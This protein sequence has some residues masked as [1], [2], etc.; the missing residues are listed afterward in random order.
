MRGLIKSTG[1]ELLY[2][3][4]VSRITNTNWQLRFAGF[5]RRD[6]SVSEGLIW[7]LFSFRKGRRMTPGGP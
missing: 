7:S 1:F 4:L 3:T 2:A 6:W 5:L